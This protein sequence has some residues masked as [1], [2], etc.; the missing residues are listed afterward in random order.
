M[1]RCVNIDWLECYC[2]EDYIGYPHDATFFE[3]RGWTVR[4]RDYGTPMYEQMF[5]VIDTYGEPYAEIRRKPKSDNTKNKGIFDPMSCHV[6]LV[7]RSCYSDHAAEWFARFLDENGFCFRRISRIDICLDFERFDFG[8]DPQKFIQR[9][10]AG[11]YAKINQA[12]ISAHGLDQWDGRQWNS[13]SWGS[14]KSMVTTRL[15][16]KTM[17][18][19]EGKDKPYIRQSWQATGLVDDWVSLEKHR[20]DG[21]TYKPVIWRLEFAVKSGTNNWFVCE[22]WNGDRRKLQ[23]YRNTLDIYT[24]RHKIFD[25]FLSLAY[26]YF[27]FKYF[28]YLSESK[29]AT[30]SALSAV[31]SDVNHPLVDI[32]RKAQRKDR[33]RDKELFRY[34]SIDT[35]YS[36]EKVVSSTPR[37][38]SL[39]RLLAAL[40]EYRNHQIEKS[41]LSA[42]TIIIAKLE[43]DLRSHELTQPFNQDEMAALQLL[44]ARRLK[45]KSI[46]FED[47]LQAARE[48]IEQAKNLFKYDY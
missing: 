4:V 20:H 42:C 12:N 44:L 16:D 32:E 25:V 6:R 24:D 14:K 22:D 9:Y 17:E 29:A 23:S 8:D 47:E 30:A 38:K 37:E 48:I 36:I 43:K 18:L 13:L 1:K 2:L 26:H 40:Y 31:T 5:T 45:D 19:R 28:E 10:M 34:N 3:E 11:R 46:P 21:S 27:H 41:V 39:D 35:F 7:N 33:C 15:Y